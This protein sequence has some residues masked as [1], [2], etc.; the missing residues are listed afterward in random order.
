LGLSPREMMM[1][2][3]IEELLQEPLDPKHVS[4]R[5]NFGGGGSLSYIE[6]HHAIREANRIFG[7]LGW[8]RVTEQM[9]CVQQEQDAKSNWRVTYTAKSIIRIGG[10]VREGWGTGQGINKDLGM[11]HEGACKEAETDA[12][13]RAL[14][15]FGDPLGL[16]LYDKKQTNVRAN[17]APPPEDVAKRVLEIEEKV[18]ACK[19]ASNLQSLFKELDRETRKAAKPIFEK[20]QSELG[21]G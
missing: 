3:T 6:G 15:T 7:S 16:A 10:V 8:S 9:H 13:K 18:K 11:A 14:M 1:T 5:K 20:R 2:K 12:M 4:K 17:D 21:G 19:S